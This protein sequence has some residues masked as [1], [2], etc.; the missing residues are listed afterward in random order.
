MENANAAD[1]ST[2]APSETVSSTDTVINMA[3]AVAEPATVADA[4]D[5]HMKSPASENQEKASVPSSDDETELEDELE[6]TPKRNKK[7]ANKKTAQDRLNEERK[8]RLST[9]L[10]MESYIHS[11]FAIIKRETNA[12]N[13][14]QGKEHEEFTVEPSTSA[15]AGILLKPKGAST[16]PEIEDSATQGKYN[17]EMDTESPVKSKSNDTAQEMDKLDESSPALKSVVNTVNT[18]VPTAVAAPATVV[19]STSQAASPSQI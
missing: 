18:V 10:T 6:P 7:S 1:V 16:P 2:D 14:V 3:E 11:I 4:G 15:A 13:T 5:A 12:S 9:L 8:K 19:A 17:I